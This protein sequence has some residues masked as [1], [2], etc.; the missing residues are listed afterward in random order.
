[1][2]L[3]FL[4]YLHVLSLLLDFDL[5]LASPLEFLSYVL[6]QITKPFAWASDPTISCFIFSLVNKTSKTFSRVRVS[7]LYKIIFLKVAYEEGNEHNKINPKSSSSYLTSMVSKLETISL[8]TVKWSFK[9]IPSIIR[10]EYNRYFRCNLLVRLFV[11]HNYSNFNHNATSV[12]SFRTSCRIWFDRWRW[13]WDRA[14]WSLRCFFSSVHNEGI[15]LNLN[16]ASSKSICMSIIRILTC[17]SE[18]LVLR[19]KNGISY[20]I[21]AIVKKIKPLS[22]SSFLWKKENRQQEKK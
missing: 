13:I 9:D 21:V 5:S 12:F 10:W 4:Q 1:M 8:K 17:H 22:D 7:Q 15:L 18:N 11:M 16:S 3:F 6:T 2:C 19:S 14:F 20:F